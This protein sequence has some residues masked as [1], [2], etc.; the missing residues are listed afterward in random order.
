VHSGSI[1]RVLQTVG[2]GPHRLNI[3]KRPAWFFDRKKYGGILVD[4]GA[5]QIDQF[6]HFTGST[7][8]QV[9]VSRTGNLSHAEYP[10]LEDFGEMLLQGDRG[11]GYA[12]VDWHTPPALEPDGRLFILGTEGQIEIRKDRDVLGRSGHSH[13]F[14][15]NRDGNQYIDS[16]SYPLLYGQL[17]IQDVRD[18][19]ETA[20]TQAHCFLVC[21]LAI[22]AQA[23]AA[24][25]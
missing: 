17:F 20:M 22:E 12:R 21:R 1:G 13:L 8:A 7:T 11:S 10:E 16:S 24:G 2:L 25:M 18:R 3:D 5:H 19:T 9:V 15:A 23:S 4:I 14:L 6:L